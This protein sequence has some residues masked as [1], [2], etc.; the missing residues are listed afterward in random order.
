MC[1]HRQRTSRK[2]ICLG[3]AICAHKIYGGTQD[4]ALGEVQPRGWETTLIWRHDIKSR[5]YLLIPKIRK[6]EQTKLHPKERVNRTFIL[7]P[8]F[9]MVNKAWLRWCRQRDVTDVV[10]ASSHNEQNRCA[11]LFSQVQQLF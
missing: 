6:I 3:V 11:Y 8:Q 2:T 9:E 10:I 4:H 1:M 5:T 7:I